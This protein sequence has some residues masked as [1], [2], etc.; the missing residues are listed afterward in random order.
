MGSL[1]R[2]V[3]ERVGQEIR[4]DQNSLGQANKLDKILS[5]GSYVINAK[6]GIWVTIVIL[7]GAIIVGRLAILPETAGMSELWQT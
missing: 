1:R 4:V 7:Q 6:D 5:N 3:K 2:E